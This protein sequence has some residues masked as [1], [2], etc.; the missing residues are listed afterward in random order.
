MHND[1]RLTQ[2]HGWIKEILGDLKYTLTPVSGD[3]SFRRYFRLSSNTHNYIAVDSPPD[4][5]NNNPFITVTHLLEAEGL[6]VPHIYY[7][8]L[9]FGF[10]LLSDFGDEL[11]LNQ[12][13]NDNADKLY[14]QALNA[15][16]IIQSTSADNL[17]AYNEKLL[18]AE[19]ELFRH[20]F[21]ES[22]LGM[23]LS[24]G[25]NLILDKAFK[26]LCKN[27]LAQPQVFVHRD[28]HSRN[29]MLIDA[30]YPGIID[31]QDAVHGPITYDLVSLLR[32]CYI[33]WP[34]ERVENWVFSYFDI[35]TNNSDN[36]ENIDKTLFL[37]WFDLMGIQRH[38]KAIGIFARL[39]IRDNKP[40]YLADIPRTLNYIKA[41]AP[42]YS[43]TQQLAEFIQCKVTL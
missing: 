20:W 43:E 15:L 22:H 23:Q 36:I 29:L 33:D 24:N 39:N 41:I 35:I 7:S 38:L 40:T 11:F 1:S 9:D 10:F 17:P 42:N 16:N 31:Y 21:L 2:L 30:D 27:A 18:L 5:E 12:L 32:D 25:E 13:N 3:A 37:K 6:T 19:M 26:Q 8:S 28:Y 34:Q 14:S 4:K